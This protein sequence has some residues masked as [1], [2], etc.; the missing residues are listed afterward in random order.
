MNSSHSILS[1][2]VWVPPPDSR[3][4]ILTPMLITVMTISSLLVLLRLI[5]RIFLIKALGVDDL[6]SVASLSAN[7]KAGIQEGEGTHIH[8][9]PIVKLPHYLSLVATNELLF[10]FSLCIVRF[11]N[12]AFFFRL[13]R[14]KWFVRGI[15]AVG[16]LVFSITLIAVAFILSKCKD[17]R[18][19]WNINNPN[20]ECKSFNAELSVM[21]F[22]AAMGIFIDMSIL[23]LP[24]WI[25][26]RKMKF[27]PKMVRVVLIF[28]VG[29]L[30]IIAGVLRLIYHV[31]NFDADMY[32]YTL[33]LSSDLNIETIITY[34]VGVISLWGGIEGHLGLW[35]ACFP[36]L[37]PL[38]R[39]AG[40]KLSI[41]WRTQAV[42]ERHTSYDKP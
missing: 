15:Y 34:K 10:I 25:V 20:R 23:A 7:M 8:E 36:A 17:V 19:L 5:T 39:L 4:Y 27:S 12:L 11:S 30:S 22:H 32:V 21:I 38:F 26:F 24:I 37:Q 28:C 9:V 29:A 2:D 13:S 16:F 3:A 1:S 33:Q 40:A 6:L 18:D 31:L 41:S 14:D 35:T 42:K